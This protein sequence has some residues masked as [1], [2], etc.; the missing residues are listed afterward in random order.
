VLAHSILNLRV[1]TRRISA[2][3]PGLAS[4]RVW[5]LLFTGSFTVV[6]AVRWWTKMSQARQ[7][8]QSMAGRAWVEDVKL[9]RAGCAT[10]WSG[11]LLHVA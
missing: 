3:W 9:A 11:H 4:Q 2:S 1:C 10:C 6:L 7:G 8:E 5:M